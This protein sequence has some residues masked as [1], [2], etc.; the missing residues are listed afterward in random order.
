MTT[1]EEFNLC[2]QDDNDEIFV[3]FQ[4]TTENLNNDNKNKLQ[5]EYDEQTTEK[6]RVLRL[7]KMDP[8]SLTELDEKY[9]FKFPYKWDPY[10]GERLGTDPDGPLYFDPDLLIKYYYTK[11]LDKLWSQP[12]DDDSGY[13]QGYYDNGVGADDNF[14]VT[15]RGNHPE[16]YLFRLPIIDCYLTKTHNEQFITFGPK[17]TFEEIKEIEKLAILRPNNYIEQFGYCRPSLIKL[18]KYYDIAVAK[19]PAASD[20][21]SEL[22]EYL[23][24]LK[25]TDDGYYAKI[26]RIAVDCLIKIKG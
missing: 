17:L 9:A 4:D 15:G 24:T 6:Y 12:T 13:Y 7:R 20:I 21:E 16:W 8:F 25:S 10:T 3:S 22:K 11:R 2:D 26:N 18:K 23:D 1:F 5:I 19:I 14:Y